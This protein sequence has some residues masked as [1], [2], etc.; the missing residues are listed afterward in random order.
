MLLNRPRDYFQRPSHHTLFATFLLSRKHS[1]WALDAEFIRTC[2]KHILKDIANPAKP[3]LFIKK[4][5]PLRVE[6]LVAVVDAIPRPGWTFIVNGEIIADGSKF[7]PI[8]EPGQE[9]FAYCISGHEQQAAPETMDDLSSATAPRTPSSSEAQA[10]LCFDIKDFDSDGRASRKVKL[11]LAKTLFYNG[12]QHTMVSSTW[13]ENNATRRFELVKEQQH[14]HATVTIP[15]LHSIKKHLPDASNRWFVTSPLLPLTPPREVKASMGNI[16]RQIGDDDGPASTELE[17]AVMK[18]YADNDLPVEAAAVWALVVPHDTAAQLKAEGALDLMHEDAEGQRQRLAIG[19]NNADCFSSVPYRLMLRGARL[20][21]VLSGGGGWGKKAGLLSLDPESDYSDVDPTAPPRLLDLDSLLSEPDPVKTIASPG[22]YVRFYIAPNLPDDALPPQG[23]NPY[24]RQTR[25]AWRVQ[26]LEFGV[27]PSTMDDVP[28]SAEEAAEAGIETTRQKIRVHERHF[29]ALSE[30]GMSVRIADEEGVQTMLSKVDVP[31]A[32]FSL[33][34]YHHDPEARNRVNEAEKKLKFDEDEV[35]DNGAEMKVKHS[36]G[37]APKKGG[38]AKLKLRTQTADQDDSGIPL[39]QA[40]NGRLSDVT[41]HGN[42]PKHA[43]SRTFAPL[44]PS[45]DATLLAT[46][47]TPLTT[48][49]F[50]RKHRS[51]PRMIHQPAPKHQ[52]LKDAADDAARIEDKVRAKQSQRLKEIARL[53]MHDQQTSSTDDDAGA[54][55]GGVVR[56][57]VDDRLAFA[58]DARSD[59]HAERATQTG[60]V[61]HRHHVSGLEDMHMHNRDTSRPLS[62]KLVSCLLYTSPSPRD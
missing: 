61:I 30:G 13:V 46:L 58:A 7:S 51:E 41:R 49:P 6:L 34:H 12:L 20:H 28:L 18:F 33:Q 11:P 59:M 55:A 43:R 15:V 31:Y 17:T 23:Q 32:R 27:L 47:D 10:T 29:G 1:N 38:Q 2:V 56:R 26:S 50:I 4:L 22:D 9:G 44:S 40:L 16:I 48:N 54:S 39:N 24:G 5:P 57:Y 45:D 53:K 36:R 14:Q 19:L 52:A 21:K 62:E 35:V 60:P 8:E 37:S 42:L 3:T 25:Q